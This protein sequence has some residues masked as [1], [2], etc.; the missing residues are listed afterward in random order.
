M[1]E[2]I[3]STNTNRAKSRWLLT[4][5]IIF[6]ILFI[7]AG[8]GI[9]IFDRAFRGKIYP[10]IFIGNFNIGGQ[11]AEAAKQIINKEIDRLSQRG[12]IFSYRSDQT[13]LTPVITSAGADAARQIINFDVD[14]TVNEAINY[15]RS[16]N[17]FLNLE[18][19]LSALITKKQIPLAVFAN[20]EEIVKI[21][22]NNFT[23][24]YEPAR[25]ASLIIE[26][27]PT[28]EY[29]ISIAEEKSGKSLNNETAI[30]QLITNLSKLDASEI[31]LSTVTEYPK[32]LSRDCLNI[33][34]KTRAF[35]NFAPL[36]LKYAEQQWVINQ[37]QL[38]SMLALKINDLTGD[39]VGVGW[40]NNMLKAYLTE[41]IAPE[42]NKAPMEAKFS[43]ADGKVAEFQNGQDGLSLDLDASIKKI[44]EQTAASLPVDQELTS[45]IDLIVKTQPTLTSAGD[46]NDYGI[47]EIIGIGTSN[48]AGSPPNRRHNIKVGAN[49]VNGSLIK[50]GEEFSLLKVLGEVS[51]STGYLPELVIK[52][53]KTLPEYGG[54]LCQVGTTMFR[55]VIASGLPVTLRRN[56][57]YRVQYYEPAGTDATIYDPWPDFRFVNDQPTYILIQTKMSGDILSFEFWGTRDGRVATSTKSTIYNIVKPEPPK[58]IET[59]DLKPGVKKCTEHAHNGADAYFDYKVTYVD[60]TVKEKRFSSHYV[61]WQEVCL[62]GVKELTPPPDTMA[63]STPTANSTN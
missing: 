8:A 49:S 14:E 1:T 32:I 31:K 36:T 60:G 13:A 50:P 16:D 26:P 19:K 41:K 20:Q 25:D 12:V 39:K 47:K 15:G 7:L 35:L 21:L 56:H 34:N 55:S 57:S 44:E 42:I 24:A 11:T 63:S 43:I 10:H 27:A 2:E 22:K 3:I 17:F 18:S 46:L 6:F 40:D 5:A 29:K 28:G 38:A 30:S 4:L 52:E 51:S 23:K 48:F 61:P 53:N 58:I 54:G 62:L 59:L 37:D 33:E 45:P 9:L